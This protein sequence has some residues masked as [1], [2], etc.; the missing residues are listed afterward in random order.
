MPAH[1]E[2]PVKLT[3]NKLMWYALTDAPIYYEIMIDTCYAGSAGPFLDVMRWVQYKTL[4]D[5]VNRTMPADSLQLTLLSSAT[6][7]L[8]KLDRFQK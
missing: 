2:H 5:H 3:V 7:P 1:N 8:L 4:L 6:V